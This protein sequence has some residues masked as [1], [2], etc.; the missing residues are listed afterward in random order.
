MSLE[1]RTKGSEFC[2]L[3]RMLIF[4][5]E[6]IHT[7]F[8]HF[9]SPRSFTLRGSLYTDVDNGLLYLIDR[10]LATDVQEGEL[11]EVEPGRRVERVIGDRKVMMEGRGVSRRIELIEVLRISRA[12]LSVPPPVLPR[13]EFLHRISRRWV[14]AD[15]DHLDKVIAL[16]LVSSPPSVY[17]DGGLGSQGLEVY[18]DTGKG[19]PRD[20]ASDVMTLLPNEFRVRGRSR[21]HYSPLDTVR[22]ITSLESSRAPEECYT[23][24]KPH[25]VSDAWTR[26]KLPIALPFILKDAVLRGKKNEFDLDVLDYQL[27]A[28]YMPPPPE[29]EVREMAE[30]AVMSAHRQQLFDLGGVG[31]PEPL[32]AL[33]LA[34]SFSRLN[35][36]KVLKGRRYVRASFMGLEEG[37]RLYS[38]LMKQGLEEVRIRAEEERFG[39]MRS[40]PWRERLK[41][42]DRRIYYQL[43]R[44]YEDRGLEQVP[45]CSILPGEDTRLVDEAL[46]RLNR[47][48]Y[49]LFMKGGTEVRIVITSHP[50]DQG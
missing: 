18:R 31:E 6:H 32:G 7:G 46:D 37:E 3:E 9:E 10:D 38:I 36:G 26:Q 35:V 33:R 17:G 15:S 16:L 40:H 28:M 24:V 1:K 43:R 8:I 25:R 44:D 47:Y 42:I 14:D 49:V 30:R 27:T 5:R 19:T 22:G 39:G 23:I 50:E 2:P 48:G 45:R 34:L 12:R 41:E 21:Y 20:V 13:D 29:K 4:D 11:V